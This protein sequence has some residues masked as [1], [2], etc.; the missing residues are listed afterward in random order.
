MSIDALPINPR[1]WVEGP[2]K[3]LLLEVI[4]PRPRVFSPLVAW[5][6]HFV[7]ES[8]ARCDHIT[9]SFGNLLEKLLPRSRRGPAAGTFY[10][11]PGV[12]TIR[13]TVTDRL[14]RQSSVAR[15]IR[16]TW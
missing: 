1:P 7:S 4:P 2:P 5:R 6:G 16:V 14:G 13:M 11:L 9:W 15:T 10:M 12:K 8:I 3:D